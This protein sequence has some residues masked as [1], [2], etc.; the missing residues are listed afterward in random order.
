MEFGLSVE[1]QFA[2]WLGQNHHHHHDRNVLNRGLQLQLK[3]T[4][5]IDCLRCCW[6]EVRFRLVALPLSRLHP[7]YWIGFIAVPENRNWILGKTRFNDK[8]PPDKSRV[9]CGSWSVKDSLALFYEANPLKTFKAL[10]SETQK[11]TSSV[12]N[13]ANISMTAEFQS[14]GII[15][16]KLG[17]I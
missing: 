14:S 10:I 12:E 11:H 4:L 13:G 17:W 9:G 5:L 15:I 8:D 3:C 2:Y 16:I 7:A 1:V 6:F